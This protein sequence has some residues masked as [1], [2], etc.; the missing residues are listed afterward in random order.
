MLIIT[1]TIITICGSSYELSWLFL[2]LLLLIVVVVL[3]GIPI[4]NNSPFDSRPLQST[5]MG[6]TS[7]QES[8][9]ET[10]Y[11]CKSKVIKLPCSLKDPS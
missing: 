9:N 2:I 4:V 10:I 11:T 6:P 7:K 8:I 3:Y 1:A 5:I